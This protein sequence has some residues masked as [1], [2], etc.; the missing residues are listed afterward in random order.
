MQGRSVGELILQLY[1]AVGS[2]T[3]E[4]SGLE[5]VLSSVAQLNVGKLE[6]EG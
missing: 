3:Y 1:D 5:N 6:R 4:E 2:C